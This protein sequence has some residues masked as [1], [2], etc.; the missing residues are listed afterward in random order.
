MVISRLVENSTSASVAEAIND[1]LSLPVIGAA[2]ADL[3]FGIKNVYSREQ[4]S[5]SIGANYS[6]ALYDE[7]VY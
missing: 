1:I 7:M 3:G 4:F 6:S 5:A 2:A